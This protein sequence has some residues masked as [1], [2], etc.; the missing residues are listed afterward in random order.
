[1]F[2]A[3]E[4]TD[5]ILLRNRRKLSP[6]N[7]L[8]SPR[9]RNILL[10]N[11]QDFKADIFAFF[12]AIQPEGDEIAVFGDH[13]KMLRDRSGSSVAFPDR[14]RVKQSDRIFGPILELEREVTVVDVASD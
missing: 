7:S 10:A 5:N 6:I 8:Q 4:R 12:V 13:L 1:M 14:W 2:Q 9:F 11:V 3:F